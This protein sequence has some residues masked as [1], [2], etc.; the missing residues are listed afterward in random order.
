[1]KAAAWVDDNPYEAAQFLIEKEYLSGDPQVFGDILA[2]YEFTPSVQGGY[3]AVV[4][5]VNEFVQ[6]GLLD[7]NTEKQLL[8]YSVSSALPRL[9]L[10]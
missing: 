8:P 6:I 1:M 9:T 2:S 4:K 5:N 3:E 7:A 10:I